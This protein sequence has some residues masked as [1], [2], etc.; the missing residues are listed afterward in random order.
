MFA[1]LRCEHG[2]RQTS[3]RGVGNSVLKQGVQK[4]QRISTHVSDMRH[5]LQPQRAQ[6]ERLLGGNKERKE[7]KVS[8]HEKLQIELE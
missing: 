2:S 4:R 5:S 8:R 7:K 6:Q 3:P 1:R